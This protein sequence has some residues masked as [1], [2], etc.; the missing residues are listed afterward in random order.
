MFSATKKLLILLS[1]LILTIP[2]SAQNEVNRDKEAK[3]SVKA[4]CPPESHLTEPSVPALP[5]KGANA[6]SVFLNKKAYAANIDKKEE[7]RI[8]REKWKELLGMDIFYPY[9]K[10]KEVEDWVRDRASIKIF[11]IKGRPKF[12]NNQIKYTFKIIF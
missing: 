4:E 7:R 3:S 10:A 2:L 9:F 8:L 11:N 5:K 12:E 6:F 1:V